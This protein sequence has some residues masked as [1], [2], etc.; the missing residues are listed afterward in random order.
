LC[1]CARACVQSFRQVVKFLRPT[2]LIGVSA[3]AGAF[4]EEVVRVMSAANERPLVFPLSNPTSQAECTA[5]QA[6]SAIN[7]DNN[8]NNKNNKNKL[9]KI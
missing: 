2:C 4:S 1:V 6:R 5:D 9:I 3:Q 8:N 7:N